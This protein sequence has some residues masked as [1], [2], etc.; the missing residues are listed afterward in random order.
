MAIFIMSIPIHLAV[1]QVPLRAFI[2]L[3]LGSAAL[4]E[5]AI[6]HATRFVRAGLSAEAEELETWEA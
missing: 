6:D 1:V 5:R 2:G 3:D 4:R